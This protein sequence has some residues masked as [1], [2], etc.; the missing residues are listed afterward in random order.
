MKQFFLVVR[1]LIILIVIGNIVNGQTSYQPGNT[2]RVDFEGKHKIVMRTAQTTTYQPGIALRLDFQGMHKI[3]DHS[4]IVQP[5]Y[6]PGPVLRIDF[7]GR[8]KKTSN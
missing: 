1:F 7:E 3:V 4:R 6:N 2:L 5:V 8:H